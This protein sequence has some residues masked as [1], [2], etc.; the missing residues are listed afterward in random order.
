M[1]TRLM[2]T[3]S[4]ETYHREVVLHSGMYILYIHYCYSVYI[5][6]ITY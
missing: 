6:L 4:Q 3:A 5:V 2:T 1:S